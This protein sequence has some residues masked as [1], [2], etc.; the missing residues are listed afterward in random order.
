MCA[1]RLG[2]LRAQ[3]RSL[4][5]RAKGAFVQVMA[6]AHAATR[7]DGFLIRRKHPEPGP[8]FACTW[9]LV[10]HAPW[11]LY[12]RSI[13]GPVVLPQHL[14]VLQLSSQILL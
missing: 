9:I 5:C 3:R 2:N 6:P 11:R 8:A 4:D 1:D 7:I 12:P 14:G 13:G 10:L